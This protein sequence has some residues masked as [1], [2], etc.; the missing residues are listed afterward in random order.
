MAA[1][2]QKSLDF[3]ISFI[4][5]VLLL[6]T[7]IGLKWQEKKHIFW[8]ANQ[9]YPKPSVGA[10]KPPR[11]ACPG[12]KKSIFFIYFF[13]K[14]KKVKKTA[15]KFHSIFSYFLMKFS[16]GTVSPPCLGWGQSKVIC[17]QHFP[18]LRKT[19]QNYY[20]LLI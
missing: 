3:W 12:L 11:V 10:R 16:R 4:L 19:K 17:S 1:T 9:S 20:K 18:S 13:I 14:N 8:G 5:Q 6:K 7:Q 15:I 2:Y